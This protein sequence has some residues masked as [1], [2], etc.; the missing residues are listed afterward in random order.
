MGLANF[1]GHSYNLKIFSA[2]MPGLKQTNN[3]T[4]F[5]YDFFL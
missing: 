4:G 3:T 5:D 1:Y 2:L